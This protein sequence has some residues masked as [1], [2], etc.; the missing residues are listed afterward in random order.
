MT[1]ISKEQF[2]KNIKKV[3]VKGS[4]LSIVKAKAKIKEQIKTDEYN[5]AIKVGNIRLF[6]TSNTNYCGG[7]TNGYGKGF[8]LSSIGF[9]GGAQIKL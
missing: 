2:S 7:K 8:Y 9:T 1:T 4:G 3:F 6:Y 5:T